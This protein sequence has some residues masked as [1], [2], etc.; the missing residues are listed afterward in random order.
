MA[1]ETHSGKASA[2]DLTA[3]L[4]AAAQAASFKILDTPY[5]LPTLR[6]LALPTKS[7]IWI[8]AD[9]PA[10]EKAAL[11]DAL[12]GHLARYAHPDTGDIGFAGY[13][14]QG[15]QIYQQGTRTIASFADRLVAAAAVGGSVDAA[16]QVVAWAA[17]TQSLQVV[18]YLSLRGVEVTKSV[19]LRKGVR[20]DRL[21]P[22]SQAE[23]FWA[24]N[25]GATVSVLPIDDFFDTYVLRVECAASPV[26][27]VQEPELGD[28]PVRF[29]TP[30]RQPDVEP[31]CLLDAVS[32]V[33]NTGAYIVQTWTD[34][35]RM[36]R[37]LSASQGISPTTYNGPLFHHPAPNAQTL[38]PERVGEVG[39]VLD[40]RL[41][42]RDL[43]VAIARWKNSMIAPDIW[44]RVIDLRTVVESLYTKA[45]EPGELKLRC[46]LA[47]AFHLGGDSAE[48]RAEHYDRLGELYDAAS[49]L[50][51]NGVLPRKLRND[52]KSLHDLV[53]WS[54]QACRNAIL[55]R[56]REG[57]APFDASAFR[58]LVLGTGP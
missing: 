5:D 6:R 10:L 20:F 27:Y 24:L 57:N 21:P 9:V 8:S 40:Q 14:V 49:S 11:V 44:N 48:S 41:A 56:L 17:G 42:R 37:I 2:E 26:F 19:E 58:A 39:E 23:R 55:K 35:G 28:S 1:V 13:D 25:Y 33:C 53:S 16:A 52:R 22:P 32:L 12:G 43:D 31:Q 30:W 54:H 47:G 50:V 45:Q 29:A 4:E 36:V 38:S 3:V 51:H 7:P 18:Q 15:G 46:R 34:S